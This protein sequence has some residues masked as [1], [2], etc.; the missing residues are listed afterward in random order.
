MIILR[1]ELT[2]SIDIDGS[3]EEIWSV[4][5][6]FDSFPNWNP[7]MR[8][9]KGDLKEGAKLEVRIQPSGTRGTTFKPTVLKVDPFKELMWIGH[10]WIS[11]L[12]DCE[13]ILKIEFIGKNRARFDQK[14]IFNGF[15]VRLLSKSLDK[16]T[17]RGF[18]EMNK[19]LKE[20]VEKNHD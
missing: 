18:N 19:A 17:L 11:G 7:F 5:T 8:W 20:K 10:L 9:I 6:D 1:K 15:F 4:L 2:S 3:P 14:E 16:D 12:F 13:H